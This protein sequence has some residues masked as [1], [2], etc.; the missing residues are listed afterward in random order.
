MLQNNSTELRCIRVHKSYVNT[1]INTS[2][3]LPLKYRW[4]KLVK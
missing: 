1:F 3:A 4:K 2:S